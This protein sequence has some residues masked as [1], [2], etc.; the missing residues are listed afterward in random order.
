MGEEGIF[1]HV[2]EEREVIGAYICKHIY[3]VK[4]ISVFGLHICI[5]IWNYVIKFANTD[6]YICESLHS[7]TVIPVCLM[8]MNLRVWTRSFAFARKRK[9]AYIHTY[10]NYKKSYFSSI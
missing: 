10:I 2:Q 3:R 9:R 7:L 5:C 1:I 8:C 6:L 4:C